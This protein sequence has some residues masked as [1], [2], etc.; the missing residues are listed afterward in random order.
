MINYKLIQRN[1]TITA[2]LLFLLSSCTSLDEFGYVVQQ[3]S[4]NA[5]GL[6]DLTEFP[7]TQRTNVL[8][9][10]GMGGY[11]RNDDVQLPNEIAKRLGF[12]L[13]TCKT[14][15]YFVREASTNTSNISRPCTSKTKAIDPSGSQTGDTSE[16]SSVI[17]RIRTREYI[18]RS[19]KKLS[20]FVVYWGNSVAVEK[21][22]LRQIDDQEWVQSLRVT[23]YTKFV[24]LQLMD[25]N[26]ADALL[27][28]GSKNKPIDRVIN[29]A[30]KWVNLDSIGENYHNSIISFSLGSAIVNNALVYSQRSGNEEFLKHVCSLYFLANQIPLLELGKDTGKVS[31][32]Q[33]YQRLS[34]TISSSRVECPSPEKQWIVSISDPNDVLSYPLDPFV[35]SSPYGSDYA[36]IALSVAKIRYGVG[37]LQIVD[38][39]QAH[40]GY[41]QNELVKKILT[42]GYVEQPM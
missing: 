37:K 33:R 15:V 4:L 19:G 31:T 25:W 6:S 17:G 35:F 22:K 10:H 34:E 3:S 7:S 42:S 13:S 5:M 14:R 32:A 21:Y 36:D 1:L 41:G 38:P 20:F 8:M 11:A 28:T 18:N 16:L 39:M 23:P 40:L 26:I 27:Y 12:R 2:I 9:V 24:K 30:V 29:E